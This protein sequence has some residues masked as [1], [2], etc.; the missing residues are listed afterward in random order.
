MRILVIDDDQD[1]AEVLAEVL[2]HPEHQVSV[3][4]TRGEA[5]NIAATTVPD[6]VLLDLNLA[7]GHGLEVARQLRA[8]PATAATHIVVMTGEDPLR[9]EGDVTRAGADRVMHKPLDLPAVERLIGHL[10]RR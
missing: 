2:R 8:D 3:A 9:F 1:L 10:G 5:M 4:H 6:L 7:D